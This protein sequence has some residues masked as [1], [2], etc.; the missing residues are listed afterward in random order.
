MHTDIII[1]PEQHVQHT[2]KTAS[3]VRNP[4]GKYSFMNVLVSVTVSGFS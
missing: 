1:M 2:V 4:S 3:S